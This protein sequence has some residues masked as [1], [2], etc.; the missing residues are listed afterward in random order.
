MNLRSNKILIVDDEEDL[1]WSISKS[2]TKNNELLEVIC[3]NNG[4]K[5]LKALKEN[6]FD[7]VISDIRMPG[8]SGLSL[9]DLIKKDHPKTKMIIMTAY[10]S[11]DIEKKIRNTK[12][13]Y[14]IEKPFDIHELKKL[15][16]KMNWN[17][18]D[19]NQTIDKI[20]LSSNLNLVYN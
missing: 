14:Y 7:L 16:F 19:L 1:T 5:A 6:V 3:V 18:A 12:N 17:E 20:D 11:P 4:D 8:I 10:G 15:I 13:A 2:L 9:L